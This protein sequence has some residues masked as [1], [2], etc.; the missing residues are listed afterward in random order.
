[1]R[2]HELERLIK[3]RRDQIIEER[4]L[5]HTLTKT[6]VRDLDSTVMTTE[7]VT[8]NEFLSQ[9]LQNSMM[10]PNNRFGTEPQNGWQ[11][12]SFQ[13]LRVTD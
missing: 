11:T 8:P 12:A 10:V 7:N 9:S 4:P 5:D 6:K 2:D 13:T 1:M 3:E